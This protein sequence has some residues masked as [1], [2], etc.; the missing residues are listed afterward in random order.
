M[1]GAR[2]G[3]PVKCDVLLRHLVSLA[4]IIPVLAACECPIGSRAPTRNWGIRPMT[5]AFLEYCM[6]RQ[7]SAYQFSQLGS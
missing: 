5:H 7:I 2:D 3:R 4:S 6:V 1:F